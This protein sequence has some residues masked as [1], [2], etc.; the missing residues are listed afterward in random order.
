M[1]MRIITL[2]RGFYFHSYDR[3]CS[4]WQNAVRLR[5]C[6]AARLRDEDGS[7]WRLNE[8]SLSP[9]LNGSSSLRTLI[10]DRFA[11]YP[12]CKTISSTPLG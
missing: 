12:H 3:K 7:V 1:E 9:L 6:A 10:A 8:A 2:Y 11:R 4:G 5:G